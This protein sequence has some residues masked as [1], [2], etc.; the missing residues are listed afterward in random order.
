VD[1]GEPVRGFIA[2]VGID[3]AF[4]HRLDGPP[5][6]LVHAIVELEVA[7]REFGTVDVIVKRVESGLVEA[8][9]LRELGVETLERIEVLSLI[10]VI[11]RLAEV[12]VFQLGAH[13][14]TGPETEGQAECQKRVR[15]PAHRITNSRA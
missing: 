12:E 11:E 1:A 7:D 4:E 8:V 10:G 3:G 14:R 15:R 13:R 9:V 2:H 5:R 6:A